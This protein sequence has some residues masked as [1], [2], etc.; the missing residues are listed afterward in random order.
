MHQHLCVVL[1]GPHCSG[2]S[3]L[4]KELGH[5][6]G[7]ACD[8][9]LGDSLR[10][11]SKKSS[12]NLPDPA[13]EQLVLESETKRDDLYLQHPHHRV[14]E[15]WHPG[16]AGWAELRSSPQDF[17]ALLQSTK[18]AVT[19]HVSSG[20][21]LV[22]VQP[23]VVSE[24]A[25]KARRAAGAAV[26]IPALAAQD[27]GGD[28]EDAVVRFTQKVGARA[29]ELAALMGLP[30]LPTL[31]TSTVDLA[32]TAD[33]IYAACL[34]RILPKPKVPLF[35]QLFQSLPEAAAV[36]RCAVFLDTRLQA[37]SNPALK[38]DLD[39]LSA[40]LASPAAT[41]EAAPGSAPPL[42]ASTV[43]VEGLDGCGKST[44][45]A[46]LARALGRGSRVASS[47]MPSHA[48][49]VELA[50]I[51]RQPRRVKRALYALGN[52]TSAAV[53]AEEGQG[54][55][56]AMDRFYASTLAY[57][58]GDSCPTEEAVKSLTEDLF[59]WPPDLPQPA[60][61]LVLH[62]PQAQR[63][64][65]LAA[66]GHGFGETEAAQAAD[67]TLG[68]RINAAFFR[69][70]GPKVVFLDASGDP[71]SVLAAALQAC[72]SVGLHGKEG[73][74]GQ[75]GPWLARPLATA[76]PLDPLLELVCRE[77]A[78][79]VCDAKGWRCNNWAMALATA[80]GSASA[81]PSLRTVGLFRVNE[82][83]LLFVSQGGAGGSRGGSRPA[84]PAP[85]SCT[86]LGGESPL[87]EQWRFEGTA[88]PLDTV[89]A[90][91]PCTLLAYM[92]ACAAPGADSRDRGA[93]AAAAGVAKARL[94]GG[95][96][97]SEKVHAELAAAGITA[98]LLTPV[99]AELVV[100]GP[101]SLQGPFKVQWQRLDGE[102]A[103]SEGKRVL[104]FN[105][106]VA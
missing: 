51:T 63:F 93:L 97:S 67:T 31:D 20:A 64:A 5:R 83:G 32:T 21:V 53:L 19:R 58:L 54:C 104:P 50:S 16:N 96:G 103:W 26:R 92:L 6:F 95:G 3:T 106:G 72:A 27:D 60:L 12:P 74:G 57:E 75:K 38:V 89:P 65:R 40:A 69:I 98:F 10:P 66:R 22:L 87:Q 62:L 7:W 86:V 4:A 84:A 88:V 15:T 13:F 46:A 36:V 99:W 44:L 35:P 61:C 52:Y 42:L 33:R 81:P 17:S 9:E 91:V 14:T 71:A 1:V 68:A 11:P 102:G 43:V 78:R 85:A 8:L 77:H 37:S 45:V 25:A 105:H 48:R 94:E 100:G 55:T 79:G 101:A 23:L 76:V 80:G 28:G 70:R 41:T 49:V 24:D 29:I 2:K 82:G 30:V 59:Q 34:D 47:P 39:A 18:K 90:G 73:S 56:V